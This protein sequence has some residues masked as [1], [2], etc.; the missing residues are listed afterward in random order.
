MNDWKEEGEITRNSKRIRS[1]RKE[2][3]DFCRDVRTVAGVE[4]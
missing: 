2:S 3:N 1:S 4:T